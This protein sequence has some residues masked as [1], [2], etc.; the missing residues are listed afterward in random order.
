MY[1]RIRSFSSF[2]RQKIFF[3]RDATGKSNKLTGCTNNTVTRDYYGDGIFSYCRSNSLCPL[4]NSQFLCQL[5]IGTGLPVRNFFEIRPNLFLKVCTVGGQWQ[6]EN[7]WFFSGEIT[8]QPNFRQEKDRVI[9]TFECVAFQ[10][11]WKVLLVFK[12]K[13]G[14]SVFVTR[15][16]EHPNRGAEFSV[17]FHFRILHSNTFATEKKLVLWCPDFLHAYL[18]L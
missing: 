16:I 13:S 3:Y 12:P 11:Q 7:G 1:V 14:N 18:L 10:I 8:L 2:V 15:N 9:I 4:R 5:L 17:V 6:F